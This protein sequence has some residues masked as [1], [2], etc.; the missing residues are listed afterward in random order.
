LIR[1]I[2]DPENLVVCIDYL[3]MSVIHVY[4]IHL[5]QET[6][7]SDSQKKTVTKTTTVAT[8]ISP[9]AMKTNR[10]TRSTVPHKTYVSYFCTMHSC[11][12]SYLVYIGSAK[13]YLEEETMLCG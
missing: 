11:I 10:T 13:S 1:L 8:T 4:I 5:L 3:T 2:L 9:I 12:S 7:F 6:D